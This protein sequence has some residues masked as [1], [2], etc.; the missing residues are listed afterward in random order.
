[1]QTCGKD[2]VARRAL[3]TDDLTSLDEQI[4]AAKAALDAAQ[5][6][7]RSRQRGTPMLGGGN[8]PVRIDPAARADMLDRGLAVD[9]AFIRLEQLKKQRAVAGLA[10]LMDPDA[11][12]AEDAAVETAKHVLQVATTAETAARMA[13]Q[14]ARV[15]GSSGAS[16]SGH[17]SPKLPVPKRRAVLQKSCTSG[18]PPSDPRRSWPGETRMAE[19]SD[20]LRKLSRQER[21]HAERQ[22]GKGP[23]SADRSD[24]LRRW[25]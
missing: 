4:A 8:A 2:V 12:A 16:G 10:E 19:Q 3:S 23:Q 22:A 13:Y 11:T 18:K 9:Q 25:A 24:S 1:V 7:W 5:N 6:R 15:R 20:P 14:V 17:I 21:R